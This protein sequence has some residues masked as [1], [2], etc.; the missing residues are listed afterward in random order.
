MASRGSKKLTK[1]ALLGK[2]LNNMNAELIAKGKKVGCGTGKP[3]KSSIPYCRSPK[4]GVQ[5]K[6]RNTTQ[7]PEV[8]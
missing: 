7:S 4:R 1:G 5:S 2:S 8:A 6:H 3:K